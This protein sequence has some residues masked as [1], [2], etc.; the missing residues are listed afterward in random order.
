MVST[1]IDMSVRK[2]SSKVGCG[3]F[4]VRQVTEVVVAELIRVILRIMLVDV[5]V[6]LAPLNESLGIHLRIEFVAVFPF[7]C[8]VVRKRAIACVNI[9][10]PFCS[11]V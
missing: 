8:A 4:F 7:P 9:Y 2:A 1:I 5:L 3:E 6:V 10:V 11:S